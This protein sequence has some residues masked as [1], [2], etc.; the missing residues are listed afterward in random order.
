MK[1]L[2]AYI[3]DDEPLAIRSL[4][5]K[6]D[7]FP[8]I[9]VVG[10]AVLMKQ[11]IRELVQL[12]PDILF[13]DIQLAEGTGFD[14]LNE[15]NFTGKVIFVTAYDEYAFRAFELNA[16]DYILKPVSVERLKLAI[17]KAKSTE[18]EKLNKGQKYLLSDRILVMERAAMHFILV[19]EIEIIIATADYTTIETTDG[20]KYMILRS[21]KEWE[22]RLPE[23]HFIRIHRSYIVNFSSIVKID[24]LSSASGRV[25]L[26]NH[27][28]SVSISR[29]YYRNAR[30][31]YI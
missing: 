4:K 31:K 20:K 5:Q 30:L 7:E 3:V 12:A 24:R 27:P 21:M 26:K 15:L 28:N 25:H 6:L 2:T 19:S 11:A 8:E 29:T 16:L 1:I 9:E 14:L 17:Q 18:D 13:L 22:T 10:E 23:E